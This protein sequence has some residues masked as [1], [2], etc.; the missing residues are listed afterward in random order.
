MKRIN[1]CII[2]TD[3]CKSYRCRSKHC[4]GVVQT[5]MQCLSIHLVT[6]QSDPCYSVIGVLR[7]SQPRPSYSNYFF[8]KHWLL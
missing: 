7:W 3:R 6:G 5:N 1:K 8:H 2:H 4:S